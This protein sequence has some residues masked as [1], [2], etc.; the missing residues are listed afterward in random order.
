MIF[1]YPPVNDSA[2]RLAHI[3]GATTQAP[4]THRGRGSG[5][6]SPICPFRSHF[7]QKIAVPAG[8]VAATRS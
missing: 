4:I 1:S 2:Y 7:T 6:L 5:I 3:R 8:T